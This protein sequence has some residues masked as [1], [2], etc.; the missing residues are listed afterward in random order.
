MTKETILEKLKE[1]EDLLKDDTKDA[2]KKV[3]DKISEIKEM[4]DEK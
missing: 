3:A 2:K 1:L 4:L